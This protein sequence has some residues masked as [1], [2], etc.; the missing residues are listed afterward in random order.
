MPEPEDLWTDEEVE[1]RRHDAPAQQ[2]P[3]VDG[4][5][6]VSQDPDAVPLDDEE[7]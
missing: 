5:G 1:A 4:I 2:A 3:V 6:E 7:G